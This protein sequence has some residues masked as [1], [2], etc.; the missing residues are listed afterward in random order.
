MTLPRQ[1]RFYLRPIAFMFILGLAGLFAFA[2][3]GVGAVF[4]NLLALWSVG[5]LLAAATTLVW[6]LYWFF[7]RRLLRARRIVNARFE[8]LMRERREAEKE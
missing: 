2:P 8:R 4:H 3:A 5:L 7:L 6:F 1:R